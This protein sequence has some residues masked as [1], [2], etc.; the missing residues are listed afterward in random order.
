MFLRKKVVVFL[1]TRKLKQ[2]Q[3]IYG[4]RWRKKYQPFRFTFH[5]ANVMSSFDIFFFPRKIKSK[6]ESRG[7]EKGFVLVFPI[8]LSVQLV[9][10]I[11]LL[12]VTL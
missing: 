5:F 12:F 2:F 10:V 4:I 3:K 8:F 9:I 1:S 7:N 11:Q 6:E